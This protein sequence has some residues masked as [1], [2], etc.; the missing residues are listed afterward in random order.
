MRRYLA[1]GLASGPALLG[2]VLS[3]LLAREVLPNLLLPG[4]F[5]ADLA[6][7]MAGAGVLLSLVGW[8]VL[9]LREWVHRSQPN[10]GVPSAPPISGM[11][12][13]THYTPTRS[14]ETT[15]ERDWAKLRT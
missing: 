12:M 1:V 14:R 15:R 3:A 5:Q 8:G 4:T 7:L 6:A 9:G 2:L 10:V 13:R 11:V